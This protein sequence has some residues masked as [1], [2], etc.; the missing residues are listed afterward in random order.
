[1]KQLVYQNQDSSKLSQMIHIQFVNLAIS[2]VKNAQDLKL[3]NVLN[4]ILQNSKKKLVI[5][6]IA[7][8]LQDIWM[9]IRRNVCLV[10]HLVKLVLVEIKT[11]VLLV[12]KLRI[13]KC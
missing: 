4:V 8:V 10:T 12:R 7:F 6:D 9:Q 1:M 5:K 13:N 3:T 2:V 11:I